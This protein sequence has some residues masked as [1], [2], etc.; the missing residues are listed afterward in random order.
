MPSQLP[1]ACSLSVAELRKRLGEMS[2]VG[3]ASLLAA[4]A[5]GARAVL[6]FRAGAAEQLAAIVA[7]EGQCCAFLRMKLDDEPAA[8]RLTIEGPP[9]AEPVV[10]DLV[11][12]FSSEA[13][14]A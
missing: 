7:A 9:G 3:Q 10:Q 12:A 2:T 4:E 5:E 6:R 11:A 13:Q 8:V 14:A 1:I